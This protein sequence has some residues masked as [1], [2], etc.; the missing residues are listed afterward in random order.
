MTEL[1]RIRF[2]RISRLTLVSVYLLILVG[3]IVRGTGAGMGCPDW[4]K[5]FGR[6]VPPTAVR[7]L[8]ADYKQTYRRSRI[9]KNQTVAARLD[10]LGFHAVAENIFRHPA[11]FIETDF[12]V[13]KTW[14]EYLNRLLGAVIGLLIILT[15]W[16]SWS[17]W[18]LDKVVPVV[19][20]LA[21][22]TV[23]VQG[24]LGSLVVST[25]LVPALVTWHMALAL[26]LLGLLHYAHWRAQGSADVRAASDHLSKPDRALLTLAWGFTGLVFGQIIVGTQVREGIDVVASQLNYLNRDLWIVRLGPEFSYHRALS[27]LLLLAGAGVSYRAW[28]TGAADPQRAAAV[29]GVML[30]LNP[31]VGLALATFAVPAWLQ[32]VH[33]VVGTGL[34]GASV[35]L[36]LAASRVVVGS[37]TGE[38]EQEAP[39]VMVAA[40]PPVVSARD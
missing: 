30:V 13:T 27:T 6:W 26:G 24:W 36:A 12:N 17:L 21:L 31:L 37:P 1:A 14:I 34:F 18:R 32:P 22:V 33:L 15:F 35:L 10:R 16:R 8:P 4:P 28:A 29:V 2:R 20:G 40:R 9:A 38:I 39:A 7:E 19:A 3:G 11:S 5:C 25:N 23:G